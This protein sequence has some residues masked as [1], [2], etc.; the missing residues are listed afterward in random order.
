MS[1]A[2][3]RPSSA[4][5]LLRV[6]DLRV[7]FGGKAVVHGVDF[8]IG[9]GEKLALVG[10][11]GSGKTITALSL[12]RLAADAEVSGRALLQGRGGAPVRDLLALPEREMR[13]LRGGDIAMVFQEPMTALNPLMPVGR[14]I[15]EVLQLKQGLSRAQSAGQAVELLAATGVPEPARRAGAYP[16]QLSGGQRQRAMIA[17]ALASRPRLLL[18]DEPTTA[19]DVTLRG[20]IL[21]LLSD[22]QRQTGMAVL[23]ITH[24]LNLVRR[25]ADR[26]AVMERGVLVEQGSVAEVFSAPAHAYTRRLLGSVPRRDVIEDVGTDAASGPDAGAARTEPPAASARGLRVAYATPLPGLRGWFR[27]GEFVAVK[28]ADLVVHPGRTLGVVG[29][30]GS[31]KSTLA[32][33]L[34]GL[35]PFRGELRIAGRAWELPVQRNSAAN[36]A[37]RRSVQVVF[38]DPFSSLSPRLTVEEIVGEGLQ[39]HAPQESGARRRARVEAALAD[40]GL[41]HAQFPGLLGRYPHEFS[42]G[43]RQRIA[44]ARA[45]ILQPR[46]LVL[47]EPTSALDV[48]IQQQVLVLLQRLQRERGLS[49]L[50]ITHDVAVIRAMAHDVLVMKDGDVVESGRMAQVLDAPRHP[51]TQRLVAAAGEGGT[52]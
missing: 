24:D 40:V 6:E 3:T 45:L 12:L 42:G 38:Q 4:V 7:A 27:R 43:Q 36:Q 1:T 44:I 11:S 39:V 32:Q 8:D 21:D 28:G 2:P 37:L 15:A 20:Q 50:L 18:A 29:E 25:F 5:P 47:D 41:T 19:L 13:G 34:L 31:G 35:L 30:S 9:A 16:H 52:A 48:T 26:V 51:Y 17:M 33:A 46:L 10:E 49:Y 23:L 14:Q 22:L